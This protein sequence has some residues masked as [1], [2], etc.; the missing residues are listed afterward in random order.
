[1]EAFNLLKQSCWNKRL[2]NFN[3][4]PIGEHVI[5]WFSLETTRFG[6]ALKVDLGDKY[7]FLPPR[8]AREMTAER[9]ASL[10]SVPQIL[11]YGGKDALRNNM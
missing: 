6:P 10:N 3:E 1:M 9:V 7:V 5:S 4:L 11:I 8:F 2:V